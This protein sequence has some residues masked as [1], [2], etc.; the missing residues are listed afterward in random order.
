MRFVHGLCRKG[1]FHQWAA[2]LSLFLL[3]VMCVL[4]YRTYEQ[5]LRRHSTA[6]AKSTLYI[7]KNTICHDAASRA[8]LAGFDRCAESEET[9]TRVPSVEALYDVLERWELC[10]NGRCEMFYSDVA[11]NMPY[12]V[13][14]IFIFLLMLICIW[15][16][17]GIDRNVEHARQHWSLPS[18]LYRSHYRLKS[19]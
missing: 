10:H 1:I 17:Y 3:I 6:R 7:S 15:F 19:H 14:L 13:F 4:E 11:A 9:L 16:K 18:D 2:G 8:T 12:I 5:A